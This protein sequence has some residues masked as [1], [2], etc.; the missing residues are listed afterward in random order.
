MQEQYLQPTQRTLTEGERFCTIDHLKV[1]RFLK[2][3]TMFEVSKTADLNSLV[4]GGEL[5]RA[6]PYS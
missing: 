5:Y 3:N 4:Q 6:F 2:K 1:T